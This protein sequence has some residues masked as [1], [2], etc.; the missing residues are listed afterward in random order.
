MLPKQQY[1]SDRNSE[2]GGSEAIVISTMKTHRFVKMP[3]N[4][5][6]GADRPARRRPGPCCS[7]PAGSR[8]QRVADKRAI[9]DK[10]EVAQRAKE[11]S[12]Q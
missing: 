9:T 3:Q 6:S 12:F 1:F 5:L 7:D 8:G 2:F 11:E 4:V 10:S